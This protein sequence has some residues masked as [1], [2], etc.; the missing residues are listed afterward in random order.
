VI[1]SIK[2]VIVSIKKVIVSIKKVIVSIKKVIVQISTTDKIAINKPPKK[3]L[4]IIKKTTTRKKAFFQNVF[5]LLLFFSLKKF[6]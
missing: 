3:Y 4:K 6:F 5:G 1:V 2:K